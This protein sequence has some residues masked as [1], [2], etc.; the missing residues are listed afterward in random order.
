MSIVSVLKSLSTAIIVELILTLRLGNLVRLIL[1]WVERRGLLLV[2]VWERRVLVP[3]LLILSLHLRRLIVWN[4][5][6]GRD[7]LGPI[8]LLGSI[9]LEYGLRLR[10]HTSVGVEG[11]RFNRK[12]CRRTI[13]R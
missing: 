10:L 12:W 7:S 2:A 11:R 6:W 3:W 5:S 13:K 8:L 1:L 9:L 4:E